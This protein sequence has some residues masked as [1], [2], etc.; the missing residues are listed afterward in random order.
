MAVTI[1]ERP[2]GQVLSD[3]AVS[4]IVSST[5]GTGDATFGSAG[6]GLLDGDFIYVVSNIEN[7]NGF[8]Y[9]DA[10]GTNTFKIKQYQNGEDVQYIQDANVTYYV[11]ILEHGWSAVHL[12]ITYRLSSDL[13]PTNNVD[14]SRS[15]VSFSNDNGYV[16]LNLSGSLGTIH[17]KD[18][19]TLN[20][21][22]DVLDGNYQILEWISNTV[23][24]IDLAYDSSYNFSFATVK[25]YYNNYNV[26]V[27]IYSGITTLHQ[28]D[29]QKITRLLTT[30]EL[31]PDQNNE[32]FFSVNEIIKILI[33]TKN[34][35]N[36]GTQPNNID[37]WT[38][39]Y[40]SIA[41]SYDDS[42]GYSIGIYNSG[43]NADAGNFIG[44]AT[45][46][47]LPFKNIHSGFMTDYLMIDSESKFLT[48]FD[49]PVLF[50]N[51]YQDISFIKI[52]DIS[53]KLT[54]QWYLNDVLQTTTMQNITGDEGIYRIPLSIDCIYDRVDITLSEEIPPPEPIETLTGQLIISGLAPTIV[55]GPPT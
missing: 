33:E 12:P 24:I 53:Q 50:S 13:F 40:I 1:L 30:L 26:K 15:V 36:I 27:R 9:V 38:N 39:F 11:S 41:E 48:N 51:V 4:A 46:S 45:N 44:T 7:Y 5:Y 16:V 8:W 10:T 23:I 2:I 32:I 25:K 21:I 28:W 17:S 42:D 6:H 18:Y 55:I 20:A 43:F 52:N 37:F 14:T 54:F 47:K 31:I 22:G 3:T 34:N 19:V 35:P 29:S 49:S